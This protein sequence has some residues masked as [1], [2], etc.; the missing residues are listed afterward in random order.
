V[1]QRSVTEK[2]GTT[3]PAR[4]PPA[5]GE[6]FA[7][8][9]SKLSA[10]SV[11]ANQETW[12]PSARPLLMLQVRELTVCNSSSRSGSDVLI[13]RQTNQ[14]CLPLSHHCQLLP[15][16]FNQQSSR[17]SQFSGIRDLGADGPLSPLHF[18]QQSS[19]VIAIPAQAG[20]IKTSAASS[21]QI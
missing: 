19:T 20:A 7:H 12:G 9:R 4:S 16:D 5:N 8:L 1:G 13:G 3:A 18:A 6:Q 15:R 10:D 11:N 2:P 17:E 21:M 14:V